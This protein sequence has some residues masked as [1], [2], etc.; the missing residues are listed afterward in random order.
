MVSAALAL[1][2]LAQAQDAPV[3]LFRQ[4]TVGKTLNYSVKSHL[5]TEQK[6]HGQPFFMPSELD[7]N[8]DSSIEV[9]A[10]KTDG[11]ADVVYKRPTMTIIEGETADS[12][13]VANVEKADFN[14]AM[15]LSPIN[16]ITNL[17]DLNAKPEDKP[18]GK[19]GG[20]L[21][22][23]RTFA[24]DGATQQI[25]LPGMEYI[26]EVYR[27]ALFTGSLDGALDLAPKLPYEEVKKGD[28]WQRTVSYQPQKLKGKDGKSAVQRLDYT[29]TYDGIVTKENVNYHQITGTLK[30]DTDMA[31]F[32][33]QMV[34]ATEGMTGWKSLPLKMDS[35]VVFLLDDKTKNTVRAD[36]ESTGGWGLIVTP[37]PDKFII[38]EKI[39]GRTSLRLK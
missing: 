5:M 11:F 15:T 4:F 28:T 18:K 35:K 24:I 39:K 14:L 33:N 32:F 6:Q 13:P 16:E 31:P 30:L 9:K 23:L 2:I 36:A 17:K 38:E 20:G 25:V 34:G 7:I 26:Q 27:L 37:M 19:A 29:Y 10:I 1:A 22:T 8:Y 3:E 21:M 12:P